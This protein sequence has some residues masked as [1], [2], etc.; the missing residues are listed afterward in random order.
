MH[1][2]C[3]HNLRHHILQNDGRPAFFCEAYQRLAGLPIPHSGR[4]LRNNN[5]TFL[6]SSSSG[7]WGRFAWKSTL[8]A[9]TYNRTVPTHHRTPDAHSW[10]SRFAM[11]MG[12]GQNRTRQNYCLA[13]Y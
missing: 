6:L 13:R 9:H 8:S 11:D 1:N 12:E 4:L 5:Y 10:C 3:H 7:E 2:Y